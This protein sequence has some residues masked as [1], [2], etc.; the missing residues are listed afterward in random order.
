M[1]S[2]ERIAHERVT[3]R[4]PSQRRLLIASLNITRA[5]RAVATISKLLSRE[6]FAALVAL[7]PNIRSIGAAMSR[8]IIATVYGSSAFVRCDSV[9]SFFD[10]FRVNAMT[11]IPIP[12]PMYKNPAMRVGGI[13]SRRSFDIGEFNAYNAAASIARD[14]PFLLFITLLLF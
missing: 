3:Q 1:S 6:A 13:C 9:F 4:I 11:S 12:A 10:S 5:I 8:S 2:N 14:I 7:S